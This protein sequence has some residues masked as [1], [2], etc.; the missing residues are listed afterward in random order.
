MIQNNGRVGFANF[1]D[2][3]RRKNRFFVKYKEYATESQRLSVCVAVAEN[4]VQSLEVRIMPEAKWHK[5]HKTIEA[6][7]GESNFSKMGVEED[8]FYVIHFPKSKFSKKEFM[9]LMLV[10]KK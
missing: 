1:S 8:F 9:E 2:Y 6:I 4:H 3:Q 5:M 10:L 7:D